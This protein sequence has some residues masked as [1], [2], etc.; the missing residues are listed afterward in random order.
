MDFFIGA[1]VFSGG[2]RIR[3]RRGESTVFVLSKR[4]GCARF[5]GAGIWVAGVV[6]ETGTELERA[7][8]VALEVG[9]CF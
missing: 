6:G 8:R 7:N 9:R 2:G 1:M 4:W 5:L 3:D